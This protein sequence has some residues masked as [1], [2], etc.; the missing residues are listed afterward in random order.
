M[1]VMKLAIT[2]LLYFAVGVSSQVFSQLYTYK[3]YSHRDGLDMGSIKS[4]DQSDNGYIWLGTDGAGLV[5]FD[6]IQFQEIRLRN[7]DNDHHVTSIQCSGDTVFFASQYKGYYAYNATEKKYTLLKQ[8]TKQ[9]GD[10]IAFINL[11]AY[12]YFISKRKIYSYTSKSTNALMDIALSDTPFTSCHV[13]KHGNQALILTNLGNYVLQEGKLTPLSE[14]ASIPKADANVYKFGHFARSKWILCG[15]RG[16]KWIEIACDAKGKATNHRNFVSERVLNADEFFVTYDSR[17]GENKSIGV[18]NNGRLISIID[19]GLRIIPRNYS[20]DIQQAS[21]VTTDV[22]GNYWITSLISGLYK[23]SLEPFTKIQLNPLYESPRISFPFLT[24]F[25][26]V[27]IS[28]FDGHTFVGNFSTPEFT[29]FP[30]SIRAMAQRGSDYYAATN[31]GVKRFI[32][33]GT[34]FSFEDMLFRN[35]SVNL[36]FSDGDYLWVGVADKGLFRVHHKE[37]KPVLV[38]SATGDVLPVYYYSAQLSANGKRIY[39]GTNYG[40]YYYDKGTRKMYRVD[41]DIKLGT[42]S[43]CSTTDVYGTNWF[44]LEKGLV[45]I[46]ASGKLKIIQGKDYFTTNLFYTL[47]SDRL[48]NLIVGTNKGINLMKVNSKGDITS[49]TAYD[50]SSGFLGY[51]THMR[52]QFQNDNNIFVGTVEGLFLINTDLLDQLKVPIAPIIKDLTRYDFNASDQHNSFLFK[53]QV[54]NP[55]SGILRYSYRLLGSEDESWQKISDDQLNLYNLAGGDYVLEVRASYDNKHFSPSTRYSFK[56]VSVFWE[57]IWFVAAIIA[58]I[59]AFNF[60][61]L[62]LFGKSRSG[63]LIR[64]KDME[65]HV[66]MT[67]VILLLGAVASTFSHCLGPML[68]DNI[69]LSLGPLL[70]LAFCLTALYFFARSVKNTESEYLLNRLLMLGVILVLIHLFYELYRSHLHPFH[71][72]GIVVTCTLIPFFLTGVRQ[73]IYFTTFI[74]FSSVVTILFAHHPVYPKPLVAVAMIVLILILIFASYLRSSSLERL[75]FISGIINKGS[76]PAIAFNKLG[77]IVY[78]SENISNYINTTHDALMYKDIATLNQYIPY[79]GKFKN[80]DVVKEFK[81]GHKYV[82]PLEDVDGVIHWIEWEYKEF[83]R[84]INVMLGQEVSEKMELENTYELLVQN[85]EDFIYRCDIDGNF[86]FVNDICFEKLGYNKE[87]LINRSSMQVVPEDFQT[88]VTNYYREHFLQRKVSSYKEFPIQKK[89]GEIVWIGQHVTTIFAPGSNSYI[90][91]FIALA[92]D[93]S[94]FR[95]QQQLIKDQRDD[96][97]SSISYAQRIQFNLLPHER[98]F[99]SGFKEHFIIYKP[100]DI[101]SGDFYWMETVGDQIVLALA[102]CTG[103]GVPGSFMTLLGIN[104]LN[105]VVKENR[106]T[107]PGKILD[108][109]DKRL[110]DILPRN[111]NI[112]SLNDGMEITV[113]VIDANKDEMAFACAGSRF[114][115]HSEDGFT[116][117]KGDVKHIG[118]RVPDDF[119]HFTTHYTTFTSEDILYLFTDGL[120]DQF[121]GRE[122][123]KFSFRRVLTLLEKHAALALPDQRIQIDARLNDWIGSGDQTDDIS[124]VGIKK[125]LSN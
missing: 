56:I 41:T 15:P 67:P 38:E 25:N 10:A 27:L 98:Y 11:G 106:I 113:C 89:D 64:T 82:V 19:H 33:N 86:I 99:T 123:K 87:E 62:R 3:N 63:T 83:S 97:T 73:M 125:K 8:N 121:G 94:D 115:I 95:R 81:D 96:I 28:D 13:I 59:I 2:F 109:L 26:D 75:I 66:Q 92:R 102:D 60:L 51:E 37:G 16:E 49:Y 45:G 103:H 20:V 21:Q 50:A 84:E 101:V 4:V 31:I 47:S 80:V 30:F 77:K 22:H 78:V 79:E 55:E 124:L 93:I 23:I 24:A 61:L 29:K 53:F 39:F 14:Y 91:G 17:S 118:D 120:Q 116:M 35:E 119:I 6:G 76:I 18:T 110:V 70:F 88:E 52:S 68:S 122:D 32:S 34:T 9:T 74:L 46:T 90:S 54:N 42:Y 48:G 108:E 65:I 71:L 43:G 85:A 111:P 57:S 1:T 107:D 112:N 44:T 5:R 36:V 40:I 69:T 72:I 7:A 100:K 114:L 105:S 12:K 104:L 117:L 58:I